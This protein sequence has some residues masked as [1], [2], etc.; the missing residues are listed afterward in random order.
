MKKAKVTAPKNLL[1]GKYSHAVYVDSPLFGFAVIKRSFKE[2]DWNQASFIESIS[3]FIVDQ[4][5]ESIDDR[6]GNATR[7]V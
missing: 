4:K 7:R 3:R 6:M 5:V 2:H 1:W